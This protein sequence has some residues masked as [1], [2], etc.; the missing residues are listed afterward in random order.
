MVARTDCRA[1]ETWQRAVQRLFPHDL[2]C[3]QHRCFAASAKK[4]CGSNAS[5]RSAKLRT[6]EVKSQTL[7]QYA[8]VLP[9]LKTVLASVI[10]KATQFLESAKPAVFE[11]MLNVNP[12]TLLLLGLTTDRI[13]HLTKQQLK[14]FQ[15]F[16]TSW[17]KASPLTTEKNLLLIRNCLLLPEWKCI[18]VTLTRRG[19]AAQTKILTVF[20]V[21]F[22]RRVLLLT[23]F[24]IRICR[25]LSD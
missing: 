18:S 12:D 19:I 8:N 15:L 1:G 25:L 3:S 21:N 10:G 14:H 16:Q 13:M 23:A 5:I 20:S 22:S 2:P 9:E 7:L 11:L 17:R 24:P 6:K 4:L